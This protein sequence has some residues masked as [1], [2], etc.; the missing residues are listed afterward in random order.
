MN[1]IRIE[2][3]APA[4]PDDV[5]IIRDALHQLAILA[6]GEYDYELEAQAQAALE[7][8]RRLESQ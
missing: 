2:L 3:T 1:H 4:E 7:A 6:I 5:K 8:L